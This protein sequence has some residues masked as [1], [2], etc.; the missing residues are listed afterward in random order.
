MQRQQVPQPV[1][2]KLTELADTAELL[3]TKVGKTQDAISTARKRLSGGFTKDQEFEDTMAALKQMTDDLPAIRQKEHDAQS[4][5]SKCR[6]F[7][8][9]LA[10]G[11]ELQPVTMK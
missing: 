4:L 9:Q 7:L 2:S 5:L 1:L 3:Q 11:T 10:D 8:D 6:I